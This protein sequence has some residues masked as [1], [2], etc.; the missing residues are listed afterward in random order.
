MNNSKTNYNFPNIISHFKTD[1][2]TYNVKPFGSGHI[3]DTFIAQ[4]THDPASL[5]LLQKIN[6]FVFKDIDGLTGNMISV[7]NHLKSKIAELP[8]GNPQKEV[9]TL[10]EGRDGRYYYTDEDGNYWRMTYFLENTRSYDLVTTSQ[11][12]YQGGMAFGK[13]QRLLSD[14][15]PDGLVDTIPDFLNIEKR[16]ID[17]NNAINKDAVGRLKSVLIEVEFL[18]TWSAAMNDILRLARAGI[19]PLRITHNDTKFNNIL[20]DENN[21]VQCV[22]DLDTVMP[23]YVAYDFGDA[24]RTI[25][26]TAMEDEANLDAIQLNIPLFTGFTQGYL[27]QTHSFITDAELSS[28]MS[29]VLLMPYMQSIRF[30]TDYL[31]GDVYYKTSF[32]EHNLQRARA[33]IQLF[34]LLETN[35]KMLTDIVNNEWLHL[36]NN[37][38]QQRV[39]FDK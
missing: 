6:H 18:K 8:G 23:G 28:L 37:L 19:L 9:L 26:N 27:S 15:N 7:T 20:L 32:S 3:N 25:I 33:Q 10:I 29:G 5:Y 39:S 17:F 2:G 38:H 4:H 13:F 12:A 11:Q 30:L 22:I 21:Q 34:K 24:I 35:G 1:E 31:D 36:K 14:L 16:L